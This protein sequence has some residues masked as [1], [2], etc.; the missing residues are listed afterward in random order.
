[1][2]AA[3]ALRATTWYPAAFAACETLFVF[4][5]AYGT[6][7]RGFNRFG[8]YS[9]GIYL[10]AFPMQQVAASLAPSLP[11]LLNTVAGFVGALPLAV[12]SWHLIEKPALRLKQRPYAETPSTYRLTLFPT[13]NRER[14][15]GDLTLRRS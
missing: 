2:L 1:G 9:Y 13:S 12:A 7:W 3:W 6:R 4:W 11:S 8:D 10:W 5:F 15:H 14:K